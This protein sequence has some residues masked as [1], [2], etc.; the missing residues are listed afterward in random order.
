MGTSSAGQFSWKPNSFHF[1]P[2]LL[3]CGEQHF[4]ATGSAAPHPQN[5]LATVTVLGTGSKAHRLLFLFE[6]SPQRLNLQ[7]VMGFH[8][9][10]PD[11]RCLC[12]QPWFTF[13]EADLFFL[14]QHPSFGMW[15]VTNVSGKD[16]RVN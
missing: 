15:A 16:Y 3:C 11:R 13:Q 2:T 6:T 1:P 7:T 12:E 10:A 4:H 8:L 14:E 5:L 9:P